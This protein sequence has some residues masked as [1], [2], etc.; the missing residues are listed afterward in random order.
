[1]RGYYSGALP[2]WVK[3]LAG[4]CS[5]GRSSASRA[6]RALD[7]LPTATG[8]EVGVDES[9]LLG[10]GCAPPFCGPVDRS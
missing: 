8:S 2:T 1:V 10:V 7:V 6:L 4:V 3:L 5:T 9:E